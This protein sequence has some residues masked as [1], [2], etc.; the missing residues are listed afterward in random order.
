MGKSSSR[1]TT[2]KEPCQVDSSEGSKKLSNLGYIFKV[3]M[4]VFAD[5]L[6]MGSRKKNNS[7]VWV[8]KCSVELP[9]SEQILVGWQSRVAFWTLSLR[10]H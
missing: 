2:C 6:D 9:L 4:V 5:I 7:R 10:C 8:Y 3:E 1:K